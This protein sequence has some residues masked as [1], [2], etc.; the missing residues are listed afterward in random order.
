MT[1]DNA[2]TPKEKSTEKK[3]VD[4]DTFEGEELQPKPGA[5]KGK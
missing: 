2:R 3:P 1:K 4:L 5:Q